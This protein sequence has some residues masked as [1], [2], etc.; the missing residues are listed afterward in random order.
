MTLINEG[1]RFDNWS[2]RQV[3][4]SDIIGGHTKYL[5]EFYGNG[6]TTVTREPLVM[7]EGQLW[8]TNN[9]LAVIA[10]IV[11]TNTTVF[12]EVR[13]EG[14]CARIETHIEEVRALGINMRVVCQGGM[15]VGELPEPIKTT[16][17]PMAKVL[18][19]VPFSG[20]PKALVFDYKADVGHTAVRGTGFSPLKELD[21]PDYPEVEVIL[22]KRWEDENGDIHALRVGTGL[23]TFTENVSEWCNGYRLEIKYGDITCCP[24]FVPRMDLNN[25]P[26][27]AYHAIN[28]KGRN[29]KIIE[30][31]WAEADE[32]PNVLIIKFLASQGNA[33]YGGVGNTLWIDNVRIEM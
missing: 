3:E 26:E 23:Y 24:D 10:G 32:V 22:Q 31:G 1:G 13:G 12:P 30:D 5:Y 8:R 19:G 25:D 7:P 16:K 21:Y 17:D 29:V 11:K 4:E 20:R 6:D 33:F 9:V 2:V 14:Y 28:S 15:L 18:Y 27:R